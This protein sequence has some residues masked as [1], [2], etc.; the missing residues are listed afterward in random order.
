MTLF[1]LFIPL[2]SVALWW[3]RR[4]YRRAVTT[5]LKRRAFDALM[6][7]VS[8]SLLAFMVWSLS[9]VSFRS[10]NMRSIVTR[11]ED[12]DKNLETFKLDHG[13]H[14]FLMNDLTSI[15]SSLSIDPDYARAI[16]Y[17]SD[18][19]PVVRYAVIWYWTEKVGYFGLPSRNTD[20]DLLM[21]RRITDLINEGGFPSTIDIGMEGTLFTAF[22][23]A[24]NRNGLL[25]Y[26]ANLITDTQVSTAL[27]TNQALISVHSFLQSLNPWPGQGFPNP[28]PGGLAF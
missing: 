6:F 23:H 20:A 15:K 2:V 25:T 28:S 21:V 27:L 3:L 7:I 1:A 11:L 26:A 4:A 19:R 5:T 10:E 17:L 8:L 24:V 22:R 18:P 16:K 12:K 13:N 9:V 14:I